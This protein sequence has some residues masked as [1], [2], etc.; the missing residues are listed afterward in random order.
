[1]NAKL[2]PKIIAAMLSIALLTMDNAA[3]AQNSTNALSSDEL[4][5]LRD[6][7]A[8]SD[9]DYIKVSDANLKKMVRIAIENSPLVREGKFNL[10]AANEDINAAKGSRYPQITG[11]GQSRISGGD[12]PLEGR[13]TGKLSYSV[14]AQMPIYDWGKID[15]LIAG[16][17]SARDATA[18]R[19]RLQGQNLAIEATKVCLE[20][21]KQRALLGISEEYIAN[22][23]KILVMLNKIS[24][25]DAGR[26]GE[27][28]QT[29]SRVLQAKS[30]Q[31][32]IRTKLQEAKIKL[33]RILGKE[34]IASCNGIA[35]SFIVS[36]DIETI[37]KNIK[38]HPQIE[39]LEADR[40]FQKKNL[41]QVSASR[42]PLV[43]LTSS[44]GSLYPGVAAGE[45]YN[46][47]LVV[48]APIFDGDILKSNERAAAER[49]NAGD[50]RIEEAT[51]QVDSLY[52]EKYEIASS[53]IRRAQDF[54]A[55]LEVSDRVRKDFFLQWSSLGKRSLFELLSIELEQYSLQT[56]Y[57]TTLFDAMSGYAEI[58]GNAGMIYGNAETK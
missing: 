16:R 58:M 33:E 31:D 22:V 49:V 11:T 46:V 37:R 2:Q 44:Y 13:A 36:P 42:K 45:G 20:Y 32:A 4:R 17:N 18:A 57:V 29:R 5:V 28:V 9:K 8:L 25:A 24:K 43:Q 56:N 23:D 21:N 12:I 55:L 41:D 14:T 26:A 50:E 30:S 19:F 7:T 48:T 51:R 1:V 39:A 40:Q 10:L 27:M 3:H 38:K 52:K 6:F 34:N 15:A 53:G 35:A 54:T 47:S